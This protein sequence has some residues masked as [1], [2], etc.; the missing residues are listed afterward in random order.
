MGGIFPHSHACQSK[1]SKWFAHIFAHARWRWAEHRAHTHTH[2]LSVTRL[3]VWRRRWRFCEFMVEQGVL[4][5]LPHAPPPSLL[6]TSLLC[7]FSLPAEPPWRSIQ[8][9]ILNLEESPSEPQLVFSR[10]WLKSNNKWLMSQL[11]ADFPTG[12]HDRA[13]S[14]PWHL[15]TKESTFRTREFHKATVGKI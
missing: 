9:F 8:T 11:A 7:S 2:T 5:R 15:F 10:M 4:S 1:Y 13:L 12:A 14:I 3:H 6:I